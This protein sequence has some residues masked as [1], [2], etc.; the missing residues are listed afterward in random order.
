MTQPLVIKISGHE[1]DDTGYLQAFA[2]VV[3]DLGE[4]VV[5]VHGGGKEISALQVQMGITPA[6]VDGLRITDAAS[7]SLV[8]MVLTGTVNKRLV[9]TLINAGVDALGVCGADRGVIRAEKL[10]HP[11]VDMGYTGTVSGVRAD[12]LME[13][14]AQKIT[15][16]ISPICV[17]RD[18]NFNVNADL[19]AGAVAGAVRASR[20]IF[21]SNVP[22]VLM[23]GVAVDKLTSEQASAMITDG[24][25]FGGMIP[26]VQTA[27]A[28]L[29]QGVPAA[30]I[31]N[32]EGLRRGTGTHFVRA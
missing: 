9:R 22:A 17:G 8:E 3:R 20:L 1:L 25:I 21:L 10:A 7:L 30:V 27:L 4:P 19:V 15:L 6:Y 13:W 5:I 28:A 31:T 26:K 18:H 2:E 11:T 23:D 32:L 16:V 29:E 14:L 24:T 12:V